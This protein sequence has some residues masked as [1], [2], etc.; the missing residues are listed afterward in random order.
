MEGQWIGRFA[1]TNPGNAIVDVDPVLAGFDV[2][3]QV[4]DDNPSLPGIL[5]RF[6]VPAGSPT[7]ETEV[8]LRPLDPRRGWLLLPDDLQEVFPGV[9][10]PATATVKINHAPER[11][12]VS[13]TTTVG[14]A[15][16][17]DL[18]P[19][20]V[21]QPSKCPVVPEVKDWR[22]FKEFASS[23]PPET[24]IYRGQA[25]SRRLRT[26]FHRTKR[27]NL[28]RYIEQDLNALYLHVIAATG[29]VFNMA[30]PLENGAIYNLVQHHGYPTPLLDWSHSPYIAAFFAFRYTNLAEPAEYV[31]IFVFDKASWLTRY[32]PQSG[33]TYR[34]L[35]FSI[36]EYMAIENNRMIPQQGISTMTNMDDI[37]AGIAAMEEGGPVCLR[38][39]D[40][41]LDERALAM[42][43]LATMGIT[44]GALFPGLDGTCEALKN[45]FFGF[46]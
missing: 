32:P 26:S 15:G 25:T 31:R 1:G 2:S 29:R 4:F 35:H 3:A 16:G 9:V 7:F 45:R 38:A 42:R 27:K 18:L 12:Q 23:L 17:G 24:F 20:Q 30:N 40:L 28:P 22:S 19:S 44:A 34:P 36:Q 41:P 13:W 11:M 46:D 14:T 43:D 33:L 5:A 10:V 37:E 6:M 21:C 39:I 8:D